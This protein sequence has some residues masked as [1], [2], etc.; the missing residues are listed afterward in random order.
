ML[1]FFVNRSCIEGAPAPAARAT[2]GTRRTARGAGGGGGGGG[3]QGMESLGIRITPRPD[4]GFVHYTRAA[5]RAQKRNLAEF[6]KPDRTTLVDNVLRRVVRRGVFV[7]KNTERVGPKGEDFT[8]QRP[9]API[10]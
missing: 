5:L 3:V 8:K 4:E 7:M 10:A 1:T 9:G 6:L 2:R